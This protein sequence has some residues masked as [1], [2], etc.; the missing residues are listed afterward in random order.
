MI[1]YT[2]RNR[3]LYNPSQLIVLDS[4]IE[5]PEND[6]LLIQGPVSQFYLNISYFNIAGYR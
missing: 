3:K 2:E 1:K 5:M 6:I 4:V